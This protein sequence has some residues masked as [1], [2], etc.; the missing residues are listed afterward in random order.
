MSSLKKMTM[1]AIVAMEGILWV[2]LGTVTIHPV[3]IST[4][5]RANDKLTCR[6]GAQTD[7]AFSCRV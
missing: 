2:A 7:K 5:E 6:P 1:L 4:V 3:S